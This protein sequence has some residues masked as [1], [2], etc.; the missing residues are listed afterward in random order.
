MDDRISFTSPH[1][2]EFNQE[3]AN[4]SID[5]IINYINTLLAKIKALENRIKTLESNNV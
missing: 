5:T 3:Y 4:K 2:K 1:L